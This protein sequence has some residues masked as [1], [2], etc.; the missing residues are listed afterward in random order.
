MAG[1]AE[2]CLQ[3]IPNSSY[4]DAQGNS[5]QQVR[6]LGEFLEEL[7]E[8][9]RAELMVPEN[10]LLKAGMLFGKPSATDISV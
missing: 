3:Y 1:Q 7:S 9:Q 6:P 5:T 10:I 4:F 2:P 8:E